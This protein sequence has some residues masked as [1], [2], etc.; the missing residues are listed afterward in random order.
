MRWLI[1]AS[2]EPHSCI[3]SLLF[4]KQKVW[5]Q[6]VV[7]LQSETLRKTSPNSI[8]YNYILLKCLQFNSMTF[9][10]SGPGRTI[11]LKDNDTFV[12]TL[13]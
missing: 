1:N 5:R 4:S 3:F 13:S 7:V 2:G 9:L 10:K 6:F 12:A 11:G 8:T